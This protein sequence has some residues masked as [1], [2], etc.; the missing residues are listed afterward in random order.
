MRFKESKLDNIP[1][2]QW[3]THSRPSIKPSHFFLTAFP[4]FEIGEIRERRRNGQH[5]TPELLF[6]LPS[7]VANILINY[8]LLCFETRRRL[9]IL[10]N[11]E[12]WAAP[13]SYME[14]T[15]EIIWAHNKC[16]LISKI[17]QPSGRQIFQSKHD[18]SNKI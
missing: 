16:C 2:Q 17:I 7:F 6:S 8:N 18:K 11:A 10:P 15:S 13:I 12:P 14:V 4:H 5:V 9:E 1:E 3:Q